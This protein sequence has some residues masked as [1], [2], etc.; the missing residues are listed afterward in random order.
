MR[1]RE[2]W[3]KKKQMSR[4]EERTRQS[5]PGGKPER[6]NARQSKPGGKAERGSSLQKDRK[7]G[8]KRK[9]KA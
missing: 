3:Q 4:K 2:F 9:E 5:K 8:K 1:R 7:Q 6:K